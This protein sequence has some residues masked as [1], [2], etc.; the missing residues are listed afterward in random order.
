MPN[1]R[2]IRRLAMQLL[3]QFDLGG[4]AEAEAALAGLED[5]HD[6]PDVREAAVQLA[7]ATWRTRADADAHTNALTPDW[8]THRQPPVDR[9]ILR[10]AHHEMVTGHAPPKVAINEAV[11]LAKKY[12]GEESPAFI[13]GVLDKLH[14]QLAA[15]NKLPDTPQTAPDGDNAWLADALDRTDEDKD[16]P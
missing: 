12:A 13:N 2:D 11:Q 5:V 10:L 7:T 15:Q 14:K 8:P 9:A 1:R 4:E 16:A 6:P 3:Y